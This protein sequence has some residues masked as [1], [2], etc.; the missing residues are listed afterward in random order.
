M[1]LGVVEPSDVHPRILI[2]GVVLVELRPVGDAEQLRVREVAQ[3]IRRVVLKVGC[4]EGARV[5]RARSEALVACSDGAIERSAGGDV[6]HL[7]DD[8]EEQQRRRLPT[9]PHSLE[10][11][12][13]VHAAAILALALA[14]PSCAVVMGSLEIRPGSLEMR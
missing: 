4:E 6:V 3:V 13:A 5:V 9:R 7:A 11:A 2:H 1:P 8:D 12:R 10:L 14:T